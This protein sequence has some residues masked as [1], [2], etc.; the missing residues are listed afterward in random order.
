[1]TPLYQID[2]L[3]TFQ[4]RVFLTPDEARHCAQ[5]DMLLVQDEATGLISNAAFDVAK[6][7]YDENYQNEQANSGTFR[8]HLETIADLVVRELGPGPL[9]EVGCGKG[10]FLE[11]LAARG[12]RITGCD[13]AY[14]GSNPAIIKQYF[15]ADLGLAPRSGLI[16]RHVLEHIEDPIAFLSRLRD[17]NQGG[18]I[19]IEVPCFDWIVEHRAWFD[20]FY[21]HVN[22]FRLDDFRRAFGR[23]LHAG[24]SFGGQYLSIVADLS[25]LRTP[26]RA[27]EA[28]LP[29]GF[30]PSLDDAPRDAVLW[31][32]GSKGVIFSIAMLGA[33]RPVS[34]VIDINPLKQG[35]YLPV[36]AAPVV[37]PEA[38][39]PGLAD[40]TTIYV[41]NGNYLPE[42]QAQAGSRFRYLSIDSKQDLR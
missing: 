34:A 4:N 33:G 42:I 40:G 31:G 29:P 2:G 11:M 9:V 21:E 7:V 16:L 26:V 12:C 41:M 30:R 25:T 28:V 8:Q 36:S 17:A 39:L 3:P 6:M 24:R 14:E 35:R 5:G 38:I 13:P 19:Y 23:V 20:I 32:G 18:L 37:A 10:Y 15:S 27:D 1:V 22:Y